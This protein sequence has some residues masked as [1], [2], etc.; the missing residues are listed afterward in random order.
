[1]IAT[2][3]LINIALLVPSVF[4]HRI[5]TLSGDLRT[6]GPNVSCGIIARRRCGCWVRM[7]AALWQL[8]QLPVD[9][10]KLIN[11]H[12]IFRIKKLLRRQSK[13]NGC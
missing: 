7:V 1:M 11:S 13:G 3:R 4:L 5:N 10:S 2:Y 9:C 8:R 6:A 12:R